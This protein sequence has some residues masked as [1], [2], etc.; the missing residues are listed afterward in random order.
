MSENVLDVIHLDV[1]DHVKT[2]SMGG[3]KCYVTFVDYHTR[4]AWVYFMKKKI[5]VFT[6]FQSFKAM[7]EK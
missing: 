4:K 5:E 1:W 6:H 3:R 7:V 2:T